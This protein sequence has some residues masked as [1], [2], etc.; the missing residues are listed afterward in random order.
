MLCHAESGKGNNCTEV[1]LPFRIPGVSKQPQIRNGRYGH[2]RGHRRLFQ[3]WE[4]CGTDALRGAVVM[5]ERKRRCGGIRRAVKRERRR[6]KGKRRCYRAWRHLTRNQHEVAKRLTAGHVDL[7]TISGWGFVSSF[8]T[9]LDELEFF[10]LLDLEGKGFQ[11]VLIPIA[12]LVVTYQLKILLGIRSINL[13]PT[14]LFREIALL[15]LIGYT[16]TQMQVGF[17]QRGNLAVGPMHQNTLAD[18]IERLS[19][20]EVERILNGTARRL[21]ERGFFAKSAGHFALDASDLPTTAQYAGAGLL[22]KTERKVTRAK[23][24]VEVERH[25]WGFQVFI[26][27]EVRLRLVVAAKVVPIQERETR[28]TLALV[29]QAIE[30]LGAGVI[31]VL[32]I[33][34]GF[35]DGPDLWVLRHE[36]GI[37]FVIPAKETMRITRDAQGL[38][39]QDPDPER[40]V[41]AERR[42]TEKRDKKGRIRW[43]GQVTVVGVAD[44]RS[45]DQFGDVNH[46]KKA[47]R[48]DFVGNPLNAVVVTRWEGKAYAGGDE[49]VFLTSLSIARPLDV[50]DRYDLRSLIENTA[51]R[52]LKQ[53]WFMESFPKKT[54]AAVRGHVFLTLVTFTLANAFRTRHGQAL[55]QHGI[56]RQR[57][58]EHSDQVIIFADDFYALFDIEEVFV[59]LGVVPRW[60]FSI[61]PAQVQTRYTPSQVA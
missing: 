37:D 18:A 22:T 31:Q 12:R 55:T 19:A 29:R 11:R 51:F 35:L 10:A 32:L 38:G 45:Y 1:G 28:H 61:D 34:R 24:V 42:G 2:A 8:L 53:G 49:K 3:G 39:R 15:R 16:T 27:Y 47:N 46:V 54:E 33:D 25:I 17:C 48:A 26:V 41:K 6:L 13:V 60:C 52:E 50:L 36:W 57:A 23:Q 30:N 58:E 9:F 21:A 40:I 14:K 44:L 5:D 4:W 43:A 59:L 7:V 20:E 56:R